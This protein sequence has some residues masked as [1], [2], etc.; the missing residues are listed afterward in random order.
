MRLAL[1]ILLLSSTMAVAQQPSPTEM[2]GAF[3]A[4]LAQANTIRDMHIASEAKLAVLTE[5]NVKLKAQVQELEKKLK[6]KGDAKQD[7]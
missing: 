2:R 7:P 3:N 1:G 5:E 6:E 4:A